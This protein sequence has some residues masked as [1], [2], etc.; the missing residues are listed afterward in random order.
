MCGVRRRSD[1]QKGSLS[2]R[3]KLRVRDFFL[4]CDVSRHNHKRW[5]QETTQINDRHNFKSVQ[6]MCVY[7]GISFLTTFW[8]L[9]PCYVLQPKDSDRQTCLCKVCDNLQLLTGTLYREGYI[10]S[11]RPATLVELASC[12]Y[13]DCNECVDK[14][15]NFLK[16]PCDEAISFYQWETLK[17]SRVLKDGSEKIVTFVGKK[18]QTLTVIDARTLFN[19]QLEHYKRHFFNIKNQFDFFRK[20]KDNLQ[21]DEALIHVDFAENYVCKW[22]AEIQSAHFGASKK[23]LSLQTGF[24]KIVG[25]EISSFCGV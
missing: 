20:M 9:K 23:Q 16:I 15:V 17:E 8:R 7:R 10:P 6:K 2:T 13:G 25:C 4:R 11:S 14:V 24:L 19:K 12:M 21:G 3:L 1:Q 18:M 5:M 22:D